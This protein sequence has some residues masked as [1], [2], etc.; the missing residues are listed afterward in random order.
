MYAIRSYYEIA[1]LR[2]AR[3]L[4]LRNILH[5]F[6]TPIMKGRLMCDFVPDD[7]RRSSME[8]LFER[9]EFLLLEF[10]N[11]EKFT[12]GEWPLKLQSYNFV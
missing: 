4:F 9:M 8:R 6:K 5:E 1:T 2:E 7:A 11:I 3:Q 10:S 12:S